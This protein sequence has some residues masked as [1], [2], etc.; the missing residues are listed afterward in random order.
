MIRTKNYGLLQKGKSDINVSSGFPSPPRRRKAIKVAMPMPFPSN[1]GGPV[2]IF[3]LPVT[4]SLD[5][6]DKQFRGICV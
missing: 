2:Y 3:L 4:F 1:S 5:R 6:A